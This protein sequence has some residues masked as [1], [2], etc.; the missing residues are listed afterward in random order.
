MIDV[1]PRALK[2]QR[3]HLQK[4]GWQNSLAVPWLGLLTPLQRVQI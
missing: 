4:Q 3:G 2:R 1:R